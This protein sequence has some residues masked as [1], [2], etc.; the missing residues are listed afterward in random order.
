MRELRLQDDCVNPEEMLEML[1]RIQGDENKL[2]ELVTQFFNTNMEKAETIS[3]FSYRL[4]D[5]YDKI[6][7]HST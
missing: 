6:R 1:E 5:L 7:M 3:D 2:P 4:F